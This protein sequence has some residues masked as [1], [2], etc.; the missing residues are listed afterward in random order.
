MKNAPKESAKCVFSED[1]PSDHA[2]SEAGLTLKK[3]KSAAAV[4]LNE[5]LAVGAG[6][7]GGV[8]LVCA[9]EDRIKR[10]VIFSSAVILALGN[11]TFDTLI[12]LV[13]HDKTPYRR[14]RLKK[15]KAKLKTSLLRDKIFTPHIRHIKIS[16][17]LKKFTTASTSRIYETSHQ[18]GMAFPHSKIIAVKNLTQ[19]FPAKLLRS[20]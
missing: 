9:Y 1:V 7:F 11:G 18:K 13:F 12:C 17:F 19:K 15:S 6:A 4:L 3:V 2:W 8:W 10:A 5:R 20:T 14:S 16:V